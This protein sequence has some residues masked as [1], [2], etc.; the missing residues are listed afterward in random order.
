MNKLLC[1]IITVNW[2]EQVI[3][4]RPCIFAICCLYEISVRQEGRN[5]FVKIN[6]KFYSCGK[7]SSS[8]LFAVS[9]IIKKCY[10]L[11]ILIFRSFNTL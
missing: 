8:Y 1:I 3:I 2:L 11:N 9:Y 10:G 7:I 5:G 4:Q 6:K